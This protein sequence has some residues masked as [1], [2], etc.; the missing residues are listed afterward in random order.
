MRG[1]AVKERV[2]LVHL[3]TVEAKIEI[4]YPACL[5]SQEGREQ[6]YC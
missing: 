5:D 6:R 3:P 2:V 1:S 4:T